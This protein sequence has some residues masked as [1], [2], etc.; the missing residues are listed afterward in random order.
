MKTFLL[1][2][3][4]ENIYMQQP[5]VFVVKGRTMGANCGSLFKNVS[6]CR[7]NGARDST[8][9][10]QNMGTSGVSMITMCTTTSFM[11]IL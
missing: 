5:K 8:H 10:W 1:G 6:N 11:V 7:D 2:E 9:S 3:L 4:E